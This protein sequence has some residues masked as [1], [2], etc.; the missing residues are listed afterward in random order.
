MLYDNLV[1]RTLCPTTVQGADKMCN[2]AVLL[3]FNCDL[4]RRVPLYQLITVLCLPCS[5]L[6]FVNNMRKKLF[7]F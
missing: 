6:E 3:D 1:S 7:G 2:T 5:H 4:K